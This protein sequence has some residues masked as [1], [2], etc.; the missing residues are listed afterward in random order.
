M[1][2]DAPWVG[3]GAISEG[4]ELTVVIPTRDEVDNLGEMHRE[5]AKS[6]A[7]I[8]YEVVVVDDSTDEIT[9]PM[10]RQISAADNRWR[11]LER[12][13]S[14]PKG[15]GTA[16]SQG[17][18]LAR[19]AA[20]CVMDADLQHPPSVIP[21]L[22]AAVV[23]GADLAVASRYTGGGS[24]RGLSGPYRKAVSRMVSW[25]AQASFAETRRTTDP[26]SGFFC[27]RRECIAG[28]ELRP[29]GFKILLELLVCLPEIRI[30]DV[31]YDFGPRYSGES[32]ATLA[33]GI[34]FGKHIL[35]L[36]VY[37]P[38]TAL[39]GKVAFSAGA[40]MVVFVLS[41]ALLK[42]ISFHGLLPWVVGS[43]A[44]LLASVTSYSLM[45][46]RSALW[47]TGLGGQ[48]L[49]WAVGLSSVTGGILS[50]AVLTA[51]ARLDTIVVAV[52]AQLVALLAGFSFATYVR[53]RERRAMP[54]PSPADELS[55]QALANRLGAQRAWWAD[56]VQTTTVP[57]RLEKLVTPEI[58]DHVTRTAQ[59]LLTVEL[60]SSRPQVRVNVESFSV[61]LVPHFEAG[62]RVARIAVLVRLDRTPFS[63]RDLHVA[64]E[65]F[66]RR[67]ARTFPASGN[68]QREWGP[69]GIN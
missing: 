63:T 56:P 51:R 61:M 27:I 3:G 34:Q 40:G 43:V 49:M 47:R 2:V 19:G 15:L 37:V 41:I 48:R 16:V 66:S 57:G 17:L 59:P 62:S 30:A 29:I 45:T 1:R 28:L 68:A 35:S 18:V 22:L 44:S 9:R 21:S 20:I 10:L 42:S 32:K 54:L 52:V 4:P 5:L 67:Q 58:I 55:L 23:G 69:A 24:A 64:L 11:I 14:E 33:Q 26:L 12:D 53:H 38:L 60:P 50:F 36:F 46:F 7:G 65:W 25:V 39:L 8:D 6:L 31:P 13:S